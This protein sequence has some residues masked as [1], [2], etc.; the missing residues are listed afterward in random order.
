MMYMIIVIFFASC[1]NLMSYI[2]LAGLLKHKV[3]QFEQFLKCQ[4]IQQKIVPLVLF[5]SILVNIQ[6]NHDFSHV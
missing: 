5:T 3:Q 6:K 4:L 1:Y 2:L